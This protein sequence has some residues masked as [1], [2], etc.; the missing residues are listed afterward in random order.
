M[1]TIVFAHPW[2]GSFNYAIL[3]TIADKLKAD[4]REYQLIDLVA[5]GFNPTTTEAELAL[6]SQGETDDQLAVKYGKML[7]QTDELIFIFPIWWGMMPA[8][9]KGFFDK[10]FLRGVAFSYD[11]HGAMIPALQIGRTFILTTSQSPSV[12][13]GQFIEGYLV[14]VVLNSV[15]ITGT[16]WLNCDQSAHGPSDHRTKYLDA[17]AKAI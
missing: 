5:D 11:E 2:H 16:Q 17:V 15:G 10:V 1:T 12:M 4:K 7:Q 14:P 3:Q 8:D 9:L 6:Y 13:F